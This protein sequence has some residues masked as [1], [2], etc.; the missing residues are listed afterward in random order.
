MA[1]ISADRFNPLARYVG[2]R[3]Q[4]GVPI[5]DADWNE[6]EDIRRFEV[7]AYLKWFVGDG[8]PEGNDGFAILG[9][10]LADDFVIGAGLGPAPAVSDVERGLRFVGRCIVD[11]RDAIIDADTTFRAQSLHVSQP[12]AAALAAD[13]GVPVVPELPAADATLLVYLDVWDQLFTPA[14]PGGDALVF[15]DLGTESCAR[16][17]RH[18]VVRWTTSAAVPSFGD[19]DHIPG[20][21]YYALA[22]LNRQAIVPN[23][24][25]DDVVDRRERRLLTLP[26]TLTEDLLGLDA[27]DYR[28]GLGRPPVSLRTAI[29][30]LIRGELPAS[31]EHPI[32]P[33]PGLDAMSYAFQFAG[34]DTVAFWHS[35]RVGLA[36]QVFVG[37]WSQASPSAAAVL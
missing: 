16:L 28:R 30:A 37:T 15:P 4:Q 9:T 2:V 19:P 17:Q 11:G 35:D 29:N 34:T 23:V 32:A 31:A 18:W 5:V 10:G 26:A 13:W 24:A 6:L 3:L 36:N 14:D 21:S 7:R 1:V 12:G 33:A 25:A 27:T 8:I 22:T 20:H